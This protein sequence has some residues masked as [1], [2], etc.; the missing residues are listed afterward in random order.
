MPSDKKLTNYRRAHFSGPKRKIP[1][2]RKINKA[3]QD[4]VDDEHELVQAILRDTHLR[5]QMISV[6]G[7]PLAPYAVYEDFAHSRDYTEIDQARLPKW[8][9]IGEYSKLHLLL[10][11]GLHDGG[12]SFNA[13]AKL[14]C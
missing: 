12:Y 13:S 7:I 10:Q 2:V 6:P 9:D 5:R 8:K 3:I 1:P 4:R 11:V 14:T